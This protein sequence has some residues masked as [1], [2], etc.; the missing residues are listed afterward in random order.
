MYALPHSRLVRRSR[1]LRHQPCFPEY[2]LFYMLEALLTLK[3]SVL[4][5]TPRLQAWF[6]AF[7][8]RKGIAAY[9]ARSSR[10]EMFSLNTN[11][12]SKILD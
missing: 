6:A 11:G 8:Q 7:A 2:T 12:Q 4:D 3:P 1:R 5:R 9:R 10:A